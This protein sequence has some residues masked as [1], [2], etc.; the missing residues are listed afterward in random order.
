MSFSLS[1]A[2]NIR[3]FDVSTI[4]PEVATTETA[5]SGVY[6]WGPVNERVL[7]DNVDVKWKTFG[8][9]TSLNAE[10]YFTGEATLSYGN[11]L[12]VSRAANTVGISPIASVTVTGSNTT[13][14]MATGNT[15]NIHVGQMVISSGNSKLSVG[16]Y[17]AS[18]V[19]TTAFRIDT[20]SHALANGGDTIQL[21]SNAATY[22][23]L[24]NI[25]TV[26]N[27]A[28][29][30][31]KNETAYD[32]MDG[33]FDTNVYWVARYPGKLGDSLKLSVCDNANQFTSTINLASYANGGA[34]IS[35]AVGSNTATVTIINNHDGTSNSTAQTAAMTAA[36]NLKGNLNTT[37]LL[38][39]G[40]STIGT[41]SL[42]ITTIG[43]TTSNVNGSVAAATFELDFETD[44]R[45][46]ANQAL[47]DTVTRFWEYYSRFDTAPGQ[48][49]YML[50]FGN[51]AAQDELHIAV[52]DED[53]LITGIPGTILETYK[54]LS[55]GTDAKTHTNEDNYFKTVINKKS[56]WVWYAN[57]KTAGYS[58]DS[59][60]VAS[61]TNNQITWF[62]F[63]CGWDGANESDVEMSTLIQGYDQF[64]SDE[65]VDVSILLQG[66]ARGGVNG[67]QLG[68]HIIDN[69]VSV[70]KDCVVCISPDK[71]DVVSV[72]SDSLRLDNVKE[73]RNSCRDSNYAILDSGYKLMYDRYN[74][75]SRWVPLNGDIA[76]L[77]IRT[78]QT[79]DPWYP[80][81]GL[82]RGQIKNFIKLAWNPRKAFRDELYKSQINPVISKPG[83]GTV[84]WGDKTLQAKPSAFDRINVRRLFIVLEKAIATMAEYTLFEFNDEFT[85]SQFVN[86]ITPYLK[87]VKGRRGI[88]DFKI[89]CDTVNNTPLV[90]DRNE[91]VADILIKPARSINF[92]NLNF[93]ATATGVDF[94]EILGAGNFF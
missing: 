2:V 53:G 58:N 12:M 85:R 76:G 94:N 28:G 16:T 61:V 24:A 44:L 32:E 29:Q 35:L 4:V 11:H 40:N 64:A 86:A 78:D 47:T 83:K 19:N 77:M 6:R 63:N 23:S 75:V 69:I 65:D 18:I 38:Q 48:S 51:G 13:V 49:E 66:K 72:N 74:D 60:N 90:I 79:T 84:L 17:V 22:T 26:T 80:P 45:L 3:E 8:K 14:V 55:R 42:K 81:A 68:N 1:P 59:I 92:I 33:T 57:D 10:T 31:V 73:F 89:R 56:N 71:F 5:I 43:A 52:V 62:D 39:F 9:P 70:R 41:Q 7:V 20:A 36:S 91:F 67:E 30:I 27:L 88:Y 82:N 93:V 37:D 25:G 21:I 50:Q 54:G 46:I 15:S 34:T 87:D